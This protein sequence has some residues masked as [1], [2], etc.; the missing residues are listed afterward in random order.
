MRNN[1]WGNPTILNKL[2]CTVSRA[3]LVSSG[4]ATGQ[5]ASPSAVAESSTRLVASPA[6]R[7]ASR[8]SSLVPRANTTALSSS[9]SAIGGDTIDAVESDFGACPCGVVC[10]QTACA[11]TCCNSA[12]STRRVVTPARAARAP[13]KAM[14]AVDTGHGLYGRQSLRRLGIAEANAASS[15][16]A[17]C[18]DSSRAATCPGSAG[19][20]SLWTFARHP[21]A[22][23]ATTQWCSAAP[24]LSRTSRLCGSVSSPPRSGS[25]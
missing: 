15:A 16:P 5:L 25:A 3:S 12:V 20:G 2:A 7:R 21:S 8:L 13:I 22:A 24:Q 11:T 19:S 1:I 9:E 14:S 4:S 23:R 6:R 10:R 17:G 18:R